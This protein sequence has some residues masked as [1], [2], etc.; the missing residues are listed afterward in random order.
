MPHEPHDAHSVDSPRHPGRRRDRGAGCFRRRRV[1][2]VDR[3]RP[4]P[5]GGIGSPRAAADRGGGRPGARIP[6]DQ[7]GCQRFLAARDGAAAQHRHQCAV[8]PRLHG[9][10]ACPRPWPLQGD[11]GAG[12]RRD[13][14]RPAAR[15]LGRA[16]RRQLAR[17]DVRAR[18]GDARP[19]RGL[20]LAH[21]RR[22]ARHLPPR[23]RRDRRGPEQRRGLALPATPRRCG[24]ERDGDA[25]GGAAGRAERPV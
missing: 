8:P 24:L 11:G 16:Q 5:R 12:T 18:P 21:R 1:G 3:R 9:A 6:G 23:R 15:R 13:D 7:A 2:P 14:R 20:R 25:G 17:T 19:H 10:R 4:G 22:D